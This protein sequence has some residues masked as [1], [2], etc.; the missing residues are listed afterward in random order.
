MSIRMNDV[1]FYGGGE[2]FQKF[3]TPI[4]HQNRDQ[5]VVGVFTRSGTVGYFIDKDGILRNAS[6]NRIRTEW[7]GGVPYLLLERA[8]PGNS[9][10]YSQVAD[11]WTKLRTTVSTDATTAPDGTTTADKVLET[12]VTNTHYIQGATAFISPT[13]NTEQAFSYYL[14]QAERTEAQLAILRKDNTEATVWFDLAAGTVGTVSGATGRIESA[15]NG[16]YRCVIVADILSGA[17][18]PALRCYV[19]GGSETRSYAG[20]ITK[21]IYVWQGDARTD[22]SFMDSPI[23]NVTT[24]PALRGGEA[25]YA[26]FPHAAQAMTGLVEFVER[27]TA[28]NTGGALGVLHIGNAGNT[29]AKLQVIKAGGANGYRLSHTN[30]TLTAAVSAAAAPAY[31]DVVRLRFVLYVDG[32]IAFGQSLNGA[33]EVVTTDATAVALTPW[34]D[35]RLYLNSRGATNV[36]TNAFASVKLARDEYSLADMDA[37]FAYEAA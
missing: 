37:L 2:C 34:A 21:G 18:G 9:L 23:P 17:T 24:L 25:F 13:D 32:S 30:G 3:G 19:G 31:G 22:Q 11:S 10:Y 14:K 5:D 6:A 36:G 26:D 35:A 15:G 8:G 20:D 33:A 1:L 4:W 12:A 7:I 27:G 16:F 28:L 29:G